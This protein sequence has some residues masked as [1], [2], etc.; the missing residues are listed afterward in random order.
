M[1]FKKNT[2][3]K[4][5]QEIYDYIFKQLELSIREI[6][7]GDMTI[8]KKMK[9]YLNL[10]YSILDKINSWETLNN[11]DKN[12]ILLDYFNLK[13]DIVNF[14]IYFDKYMLILK[15]NTLNSFIKGVIN[16]KN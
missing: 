12:K 10:L 15:N 4:T 9:N 6:G 11:L 14:S 13:G 1:V 2:N 7:Y 5:L 3:K 8:N 16:F